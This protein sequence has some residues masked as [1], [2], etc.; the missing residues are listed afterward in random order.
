VTTESVTRVSDDPAAV[1]NPVPKSESAPR[2][3]VSRVAAARTPAKPVAFNPPLEP[4]KPEPPA[5]SPPALPASPPADEV[6]ARAMATAPAGT[7]ITVALIDA[8]SSESNQAGDTF[9]ASLVE[10][11]ATADGR[12]LAGKGTIVTGKVERVEQPGKVQGRASMELRLTGIR[13]G[14]ATIAIST[15]PIASEAAD[16]KER[17]AG[18]IAGGAGVGAIIGAIAGGKKGAAIGAVIGS[19]SGTAAVLM[20]PGEPVRLYSE[21]RIDFVLDDAVSMPVVRNAL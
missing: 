5:N 4:V 12:V 3:P 18:L 17:D 20:T 16:N 13:D 21:T 15:R 2:A 9:T 11:V 14:A 10:P 1:S 6:P 8:L 7:R 19:G